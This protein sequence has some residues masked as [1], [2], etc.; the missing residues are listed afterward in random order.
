[1]DA[2]TFVALCMAQVTPLY[3]YFVH[4]IGNVHDAEDLMAMTVNKALAS[5]TRFDPA[6]GT[7]TAWLFG[8]A[9]HTLRD[10]QRRQRP[11]S[12]IA[13]MSAPLIDSAPTLDT[14]IVRIEEATL[15]LARVRQLPTGQ[16]EALMLYYF[17][18]LKAAEIARV[19]GRS[20]G[21]VRLLIHR[22]LTTLR[23]QYRQEDRP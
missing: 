13:A 1:M 7:F 20:E 2:D 10:F 6:S 16:R 8:I 14:Q 17:G 4:Q 12:D 11:M 9:R 18:A 22:A 3:R 21:A 19:L 23:G 15:L 5:I